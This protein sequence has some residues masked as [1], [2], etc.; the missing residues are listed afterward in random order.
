MKI[1]NEEALSIWFDNYKN[2]PYAY[3][4]DNNLILRNSFNNDSIYSWSI[5]FFNSEDLEQTY[6]ASSKFINERNQRDQFL[7]SSGINYKV[8][9]T[10]D[11]IYSWISKDKILDP[12]SIENVDF[13]LKNLA[14][15]D[16]IYTNLLTAIQ[17]KAFTKEVQSKFL[18]F[19]KNYLSSD[20]LIFTDIEYAN[21]NNLIKLLFN[22]KNEKESETI[23]NKLINL[24]T[25]IPLFVKIMKKSNTEIW[26][27]NVFLKAGY[28]FNLYAVEFPNNEN[29]EVIKKINISTYSTVSKNSLYLNN[30]LF[31][32]LLTYGYKKEFFLNANELTIERFYMLNMAK[33]SFREYME[34]YVSNEYEKKLKK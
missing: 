33:R 17:F 6:L 7:S 21:G 16:E 18:F 19:I 23:V 27:D 30:K 20:N 10:K 15:K 11:G 25:L 22:V 3:D 9:K 5:D 4:L 28:Y 24:Q 34:K 14:L 32:T 1:S 26:E 8:S 12:D 29:L 31:E 2:Q 13:Y